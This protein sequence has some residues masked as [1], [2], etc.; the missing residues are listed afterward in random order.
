MLNRIL[1]EQRLP[2]LPH[3]RLKRRPDDII[4]EKRAINK[5]RE[6]HNLQPLERLP[7]EAQTNNPNEQRAARINNTPRRRADTPCD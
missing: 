6:P 1:R 3:T 2:L 5:Q 4:E 7:P